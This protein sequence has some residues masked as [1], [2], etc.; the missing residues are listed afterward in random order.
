MMKPDLSRL[1]LST[2]GDQNAWAVFS[3]DRIYRY[4]LARAW[5]PSLP[6]LAVGML[7]PS[8]AGAYDE[9]GKEQ[10]D[11]T[12]RKVGGFARRLGFGSFVVCNL[13]AFIA[14]DPKDFARAEDPIGPHNATAMHYAFTVPSVTTCVAAWGGSLPRRLN[15]IVSANKTMMRRYG[16]AWCWGTTKD[17]EPRHPLMLSYDTPLEAWRRDL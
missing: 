9:H 2:V 7:N 5:D 12:A 17:G 13:G 15:D 4:L 1:G 6:T 10:S 3:A 16:A 14:T 8:K 11:P